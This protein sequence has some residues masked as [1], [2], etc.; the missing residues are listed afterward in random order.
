MA[1]RLFFHGTKQFQEA[2]ASRSAS[3][4]SCEES[5]RALLADM[6]WP[7][8]WICKPSTTGSTLQAGFPAAVACLVLQTYQGKRYLVWWRT[9]CPKAFCPRGASWRDAFLPP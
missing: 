8:C 5:L 7:F 9:S 1:P 6:R 3:A 2:R 4:T